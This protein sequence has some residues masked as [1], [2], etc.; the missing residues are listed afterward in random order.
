[1]K[2]LFLY[3]LFALVIPIGIL[4][5]ISDMNNSLVFC[6]S[7]GIFILYRYFIDTGRLKDLGVIRKGTK[8]Y[9]YPLK[10]ITYFKELYFSTKV[11]TKN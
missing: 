11:R 10:S 6:I 7:L 2:K 8:E 9:Y 4:Y 5:L 3:Y 1:M